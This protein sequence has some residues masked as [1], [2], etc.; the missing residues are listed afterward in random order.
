MSS[1]HEYTH[2]EEG[3]FDETNE[4][5]I[6]DEPPPAYNSVFNEDQL[7]LP[8]TTRNSWR[9][10]ILIEDIGRFSI[11][12]SAG[13]RTSALIQSF[14]L[15]TQRPQVI[16]I[17][18][19]NPGPNSP[20]RSTDCAARIS[21]ETPEIPLDIILMLVGSRDEIKSI[22]LVGQ[23]L[24]KHGHRV[25]VATHSLFQ[26][27]VL[28]AGLEF[29]SI[30]SDP[31]HPIATKDSGFM[32]ELSSHS[33][34]EV[35][36]NS[37][38]L[39]NTLKECWNA[40]VQP[41]SHDNKPFVADAIIATPLA[42]AHVHCAE[43]LSIPLHIFSNSPWTPTRRFVHP[44]AHIETGSEIDYQLQNYLSY[45]LV[46][47]SVWHEVYYVVDHF[48]QAVL[49]LPQMPLF[50]GANIMRDLKIPHTYLWSAGLLPK[51]EDW[52]ETIDISG[53]P[54]VESPSFYTPSEELKVFLKSAV[55]PVLVL[56]DITQL[57]EPARLVQYLFEA[58]EKY[59]IYFLLPSRFGKDI[60]I[61]TSPKI[62]VLDGVPNEWIISKIAVLLTS[63]DITTIKQG[64]RYG[65]PMLS[66]PVLRDQPFWA[67]TIY[68]AGLGP[69]P[70]REKALSSE[71]IV[72][73]FRYCLRPD[74]KQVTS[75]LGQQ[76]QRE[77]GTVRC[78][79]TETEPVVYRMQLKPSIKR[80]VDTEEV[81]LSTRGGGPVG[82]DE[83]PFHTALNEAPEPIEE[84]KSTFFVD[85]KGVSKSLIKAII[86]P[87]VS[88]IADAHKK[89]EAH[90]HL[91]VT[92]A[93]KLEQS[94]AKTGMALKVAR[95]VGFGSAVACGKIAML[96]FKT[97]WY[98]SETASYGVRALKGR[99]EGK[100][101][102][103]NVEEKENVDSNKKSPDFDEGKV[104]TFGSLEEP[105]TNDSCVV[106]VCDTDLNIALGQDDAYIRAITAS[107]MA[108]GS[109]TTTQPSDDDRSS[110]GSRRSAALAL[111][112]KRE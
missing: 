82:P 23:E 84:F 35:L 44:L 98:M 55:E 49:G 42:H 1:K 85:A 86:K 34:P 25:R 81:V 29:F 17:P 63:G 3:I 69:S 106:T 11:D 40:C 48:R 68:N 91:P 87:T 6:I 92:T 10:S 52:D 108:Q 50:D 100:R 103:W 21:V 112:G 9:D 77:N 27:F 107:R 95:N 96:P 8:P 62:F 26:S 102:V 94:G 78:S 22:I 76:I 110:L 33:R 111:D 53:Y 47:E 12:L 80:K 88:H 39:L 70:L 97:V 73:A 56:L 18:A 60:Q 41:G 54:T 90:N 67:S 89:R 2:L 74:V 99:P 58:S 109:H 79:D 36:K 104:L 51:P 61:L 65:K 83:R 64:V 30:S 57:N 20:V 72:E 16:D 75:R 93:S 24:Q 7:L 19:I 28:R 105:I 15:P 46:G 66:L 37:K 14:S 101:E 59:G 32:P 13:A 38:L 4:E 45:L 43:M 71:K 5:S 31:E